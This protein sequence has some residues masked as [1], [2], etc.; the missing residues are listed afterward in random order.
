M[1]QDLSNSEDS[2]PEQKSV[3]DKDSYFQLLNCLYQL[4]LIIR[5]NPL[6]LESHVENPKAS[7]VFKSYPNVLNQSE[8]G[9]RF[10]CDT[11]LIQVAR[12]VKALDLLLLMRRDLKSARDSGLTNEL[13]YAEVASAAIYGIADDQD[14]WFAIESARRAV[15]IPQRPSYKELETIIL[16]GEV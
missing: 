10:I 12:P 7:S 14:L 9:L 5:R 16:N 15:P 11:L 1:S 6:E 8:Y 2:T 13:H 4:G 3:I